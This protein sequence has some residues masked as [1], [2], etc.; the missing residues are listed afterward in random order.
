MSESS[1]RTNNPILIHEWEIDTALA[2]A[3]QRSA[4]ADD[5][6]TYVHLRK[7]IQNKL[8]LRLMC[9]VFNFAGSTATSRIDMIMSVKTSM[10][11]RMEYHKAVC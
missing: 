4:P 5:G 11:S 8:I 7:Q 6:I 1:K 3:N 9:D 2:A 10:N